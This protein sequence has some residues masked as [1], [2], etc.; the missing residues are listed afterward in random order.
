MIFY[1]ALLKNVRLKS[2]H[3]FLTKIPKKL[4]LQKIAFDHLSGIYFKDFSNLYKKCTAV[5]YSVLV[6]HATLESNNRSPVKN[7]LYI[8]IYI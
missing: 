3:Y 5:P 8:K 7:N 4:E 6:I 2:T 1:S